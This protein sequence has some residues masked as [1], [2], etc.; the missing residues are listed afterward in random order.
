M[1]GGEYLRAATLE[2][3]WSG[4]IPPL[5]NAMQQITDIGRA[6]NR[7]DEERVDLDEALL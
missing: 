4:P 5:G 6:E 7:L 2:A 3:L 1:G